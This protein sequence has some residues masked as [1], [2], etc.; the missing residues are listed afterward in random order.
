[1]RTPACDTVSSLGRKKASIEEASAVPWS[2]ASTMATDWTFQQIAPY[3]GRVKTSIA[4][5]LI[6]NL[7]QP[8]DVIVDPFCGSGI[9]PYEAIASQRQV[10][11]GDINPYAV[12]LTRAKLFAP[13]SL[14]EALGQLE[15][16]WKI[17]TT[18]FQGQDLRKVPQWVRAFFHPKT[19]REILSFREACVKTNSYFLFACLLGILHHQR[20]GFLSFPSSHLVPYLRDRLYPKEDY[21][22][23]YD[24]REVHPRLEAKIRR[25]YRRIPPKNDCSAEVYYQHAEQFPYTGKVSAVITSPP[26]MNELDYVRDNRLRLWV[27]HRGLPKIHDPKLKNKEENFEMLMRKTCKR[28]SNNIIEGGY[29]ALV[30]GDSRRGNPQRKTD[31]IIKSIF[32]TDT[33]LS[34]FRLKKI[35]VDNIPDIRRSRRDNQGTKTETIL[36]YRREK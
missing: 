4:R 16:V 20:P 5:Y 34:A 19:L 26:Y 14:D 18:S 3:I 33:S 17:A 8:G 10:R 15:I 12:L 24:Y 23:M 6:D 36:V 1:M 30:I 35:F 9:I 13:S 31:A 2:S 27:I 22:E 32:D 21:P 25:A 28:F 7:S 29:F 11:C